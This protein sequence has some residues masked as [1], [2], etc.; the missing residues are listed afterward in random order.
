M[1]PLSSTIGLPPFVDLAAVFAGGVGGALVARQ[2]RFDLIGALALAIVSGFGG[3]M[4]RDVLLQHGPPLALSDPR[5]L[6]TGAIAAL[7]G[8]FFN[9]LVKSAARVLTVVDAASLGIYTVAGA[10]RA[11]SFGMSSVAAIFLGVITAVGGG[12]LRDVLSRETPAI[13]HRGQ[14]HASV[15]IF[16][17]L[18]L[19]GLLALDVD[20][21]PAGWSAALGMFILRLLAVRF[22]WR[23]PTA[24]AN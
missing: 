2:R 22:G 17:G 20:A 5:Y 12:I 11:L 8:F 9:P 23:I 1:T 16:G 18:L 21:S 10:L 3:G 15:A 24:K 6:V 7:V 19:I 13:F 4:I 14:L